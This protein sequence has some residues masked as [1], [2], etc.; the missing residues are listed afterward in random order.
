[1]DETGDF[2]RGFTPFLKK[3]FFINYFILFY[4]FRF[5]PF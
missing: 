5:H 1:M 3:I 2:G 4:F